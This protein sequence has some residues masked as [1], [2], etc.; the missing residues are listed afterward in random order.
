MNNEVLNAE[1]V[2]IDL[3]TLANALTQLGGFA[4]WEV[5]FAVEK[6]LDSEDKRKLEEYRNQ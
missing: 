2:E 3:E 5:V 4:R 6:A 1:N